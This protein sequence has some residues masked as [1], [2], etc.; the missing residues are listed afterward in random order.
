MKKIIVFIIYDLNEVIKLGDWI[1]IMKDGEVVQV[2]I[3]EEILI[4]LVNV[5]VECFVQSV[6]CSKIIIVV[7]VMV[8]KFF[9]V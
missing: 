5:Y 2:G 8:D 6:D 1:V 4:E 9:V 3:L 7:L